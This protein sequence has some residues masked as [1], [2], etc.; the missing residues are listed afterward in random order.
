MKSKI[1][2]EVSEEPPIGDVYT[3]PF[4]TLQVNNIEDDL[5][6]NTPEISQMSNIVSKKSM[7]FT[8]F[9]D[10]LSLDASNN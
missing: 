8:K 9:S 4:N 1:Q 10:I 7:P 2:K 5:T 3:M 6:Q